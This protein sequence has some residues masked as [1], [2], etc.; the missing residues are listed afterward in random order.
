MPWRRGHREGSEDE[1]DRAGLGGTATIAGQREGKR[2][3]DW[4]TRTRHKLENRVHVNV[5]TVS[6]VC[7][8]LHTGGTTRDGKKKSEHRG[9]TTTAPI[10]L[11]TLRLR[12]KLALRNELNKDARYSRKSPG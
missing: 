4:A 1:G 7:T 10:Y 2:K 11:E 3:A 6:G 12:L 9:S 5:A 8:L